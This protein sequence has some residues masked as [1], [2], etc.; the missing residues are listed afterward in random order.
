MTASFPAS[1]RAARLQLM[2]NEPFLAAA[3]ARFPLMDATRTGWC[4]KMATDGY[5]IYV[6]VTF[7]ESLSAEE[8][9]FV[10]AHE[11]LH[12]LLGH[13][14]RRG[15][16]D[17]E[18]WN[19]AADLATNGLLVEAGM[20]MPGQGLYDRMYRG[21]TA[22]EIYEHLG[23]D[24]APHHLRVAV[25]TGTAGGDLT[26]AWDRHV[27]PNDVFGATLRQ[28]DFPSQEE[29]RR[30]RR[31]MVTEISRLPGTVPGLFA[32]EVR[33]ATEATIPWEQLL[34]R[35][36]N[37]LRRSDYRMFPPSKKHVWRGIY[38]PAL[39]KPGP[40]HLV[41]AV[42]TSGSMSDKL[43]GRI[44]A[45]ID[46]L[47]S[48]GE[49]TLTLVQCD[50]VIQ[51]VERFEPYEQA[52]WELGGQP[53][54]EFRGRGGTDLTP[55]FTWVEEEHRTRGMALD[56]LIY[57]TDGFGPVNAADPPYPVLWCLPETGI[58]PAQFGAVLRILEHTIVAA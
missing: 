11:V 4:D 55:P 31:E 50:A 49:C 52:S 43:L 21:M 48:A 38:L 39:G 3:I 7:A 33:A 35:F 25:E 17:R 24:S 9:E 26:G 40:E 19:V 51:Q 53:S 54:Y 16:R 13:M 5:Y 57:L 28:S 36:I 2:L 18:R 22:E 56:A 6:N 32:S 34:A 15:S 8:L 29:R 37:G 45:E 30:L 47:R 10:F 14:D 44:L 46:R 12:C 58:R 41:V 20:V 27:E 42:D 23:S 1:I